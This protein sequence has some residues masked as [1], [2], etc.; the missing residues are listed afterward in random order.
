MHPIAVGVPSYD[1]TCTQPL[2][3]GK[4]GELLRQRFCNDLALSE[5]SILRAGRTPN[6]DKCPLCLQDL[7]QNSPRDACLC[8]FKDF[9]SIW[10]P[11]LAS[12]WHQKSDE[13]QDP[14]SGRQ[15]GSQSACRQPACVT[16]ASKGGTIQKSHNKTCILRQDLHPTA[17]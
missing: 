17:I 15:G 8:C 13:F 10:D 16:V 9:L 7:S 12:N 1:K 6:V 2:I 5:S 4:V 3:E 14:L 11:V